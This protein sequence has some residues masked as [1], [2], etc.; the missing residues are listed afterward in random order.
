MHALLGAHREQ[1]LVSISDAQRRPVADLGLKW[2]GTIHH[3]LDLEQR[4]EYGDGSGGY[5]LFLGRT[6]TEKGP[7]SAIRIATMAGLKLKIASRLSREER[8][9]FDASVK[10]MLDHPDV[11]WVGEQDDAQKAE[12]LRKARALLLP[13]EWDEPF[14]LVFIEA[15]ACGTPVVSRPLG[16]LPEIVKDGVHGFLRDTD[17]QLA[18]VC[19]QLDSIDRRAC[20]EWALRRFS[21]AAMTDAYE[22][23]YRRVRAE[24][25]AA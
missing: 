7:V 25:A 18:E 22:D 11:E 19:R 2:A 24:A 23:A 8:D 21:V 1:H 4:Y 12:L 10:P 15:L 9:F 20:R 16:S 17:E 6:A 14:G 3:G 5:L 13:I